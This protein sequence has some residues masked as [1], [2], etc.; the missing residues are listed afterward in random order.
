RKAGGRAMSW[1]AAASDCPCELLLDPLSGAVALTLDDDGIDVVQDAIEDGGGQ[2]AVIVEDLRP[3]LVD[4]VGGDHH[5]RTLVALADDLEQQVGTVLVDG[6][7]AEL[8]DNE[9]GRV[10]VAAE[11]VLEPADGLRR[12]QRVDNVD[13]RREE[14]RVSVD[15]GGVAK[16][17]RD[18][19][20]T[21][22]NG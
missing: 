19:R 21:E 6:K 10:Q 9:Q 12:C 4:A 8:V 3:V 15:A 17:K 5:R 1:W 16:C 2:G 22:A 14:N 7:V 13:G 20:L 18:V 11:L